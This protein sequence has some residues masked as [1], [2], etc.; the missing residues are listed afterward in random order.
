MMTVEKSIIKVYICTVFIVQHFRN[1]PKYI[2]LIYKKPNQLLDFS[3]L[4]PQDRYKICSSL[5]FIKQLRVV[6][7][8]GPFNSLPNF[9]EEI[10]ILK[11]DL[12]GQPALKGQS[13]EINPITFCYQ[14]IKLQLLPIQEPILN[15]FIVTFPCK[16]MKN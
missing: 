16:S 5:F 8:R 3:F 14:W 12:Q 15:F 9:H 10:C 13:H 2:D 6:Q 7:T 11:S 1:S 4:F